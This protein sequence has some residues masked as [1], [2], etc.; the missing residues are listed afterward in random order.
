MNRF[1]NPILILA[2]ALVFGACSHKNLAYFQ[3]VEQQITTEMTE[4][5][6]IKIQPADELSIVVKSKD[7]ILADLFNMPIISHRVGYGE[8]SSNSPSQYVASYIVDSNGKINFPIL[9]QI[10]VG[11]KT[12]EEAKQFIE[13]Q[14]KSQNLVND[15]VVVIYYMNTTYTVLGE[16]ARPGRYAF[17]RDRITILDAIGQC[18]DLTINGVREKVLVMRT[19][20]DKQT[21]YAVD[22]T[23]YKDVLESPVYYLQQNDV[24]YVTPNE[25]RMRESTVNGNNILSTSFWISVAS[26]VASVAS[27][28]INSIK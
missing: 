9:G 22:L 2:V 26:L 21:V 10:E 23:N 15:P 16:V 8:T 14:L 3:D 4:A 28:I 18:G 1:I 19:V 6:T 17:S 12:R 7:A 27:I 20:D 5:A 25:K 11:G 13:E 24:I